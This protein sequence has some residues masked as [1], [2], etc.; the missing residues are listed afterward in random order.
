M[1]LRG[2]FEKIIETNINGT[3]FIKIHK[4][5]GCPS[6]VFS[7]FQSLISRIFFITVYTANEITSAVQ[8][9]ADE[10]INDQNSGAY[11]VGHQ[12]KNG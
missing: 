2:D 8:H 6:S 4:Q 9:V 11:P 12:Q 5:T 3:S 1:S 7:C 10:D